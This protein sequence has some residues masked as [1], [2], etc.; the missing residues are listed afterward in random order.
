MRIIVVLHPTNKR[1]TKSAYTKFRQALLTDGFVLMAPEI[2]MR[3]TA[4]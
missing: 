3:I 2:F 4:N 1:G